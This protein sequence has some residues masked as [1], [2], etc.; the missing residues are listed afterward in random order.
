MLPKATASRPPER[1]AELGWA[2]MEHSGALD[3]PLRGIE[4]TEDDAAL[5]NCLRKREEVLVAV[6]HGEVRR[7][8][9]E[10]S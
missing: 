10:E 3:R 5:L 8:A 2:A 7:A 4:G 9:V 1:L 6:L